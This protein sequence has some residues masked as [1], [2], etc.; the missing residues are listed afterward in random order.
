MPAQKVPP[1][2]WIIVTAARQFTPDP[3]LYSG[4]NYIAGIL[5]V[6]TAIRQHAL[7]TAREAKR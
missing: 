6:Q 5:I 1:L 3:H 7:M 4:F 2:N